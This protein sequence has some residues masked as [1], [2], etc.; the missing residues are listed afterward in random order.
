L[1][2]QRQHDRIVLWMAP[3]ETD[4]A[5]APRADTGTG[6]A[7]LDR[8]AARLGWQLA[9]DAPGRVSIRLRRSYATDS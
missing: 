3:E 7:L 8:L 5:I 1:H 6:S 9:F 4:A 2:L